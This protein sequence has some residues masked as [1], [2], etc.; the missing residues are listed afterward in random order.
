[1]IKQTAEIKIN[2]VNTKVSSDD[3]TLAGAPCPSTVGEK[4]QT[5]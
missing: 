1:M 3:P 4:A 2:L 5:R